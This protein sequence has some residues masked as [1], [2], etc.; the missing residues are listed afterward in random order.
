MRLDRFQKKKG[1][2]TTCSALN[3]KPLELQPEFQCFTNHQIIIHNQDEGLGG[4]VA[5][6]PDPPPASRSGFRGR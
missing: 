5:I 3:V 4:G 6:H 1:V 2:I